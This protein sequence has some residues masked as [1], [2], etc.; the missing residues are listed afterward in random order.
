MKP[1]VLFVA[2]NRY[3]VP[4]S[5]SLRRKWDALARVLEVAR[6]RQSARG[7]ATRRSGSARD[8]RSTGRASGCRCPRAS[9]ASCAAFRPDAIVAQSPFEAA[10]GAVARARRAR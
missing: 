4:L 6:A 1:R 10:R 9:G 2:R 5:P 8:A 3:R 7:R